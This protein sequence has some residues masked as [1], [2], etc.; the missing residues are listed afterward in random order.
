[1]TCYQ[2]TNLPSG[3]PTTG[4]TSYATEA[5][6]N[7]AC[8][9]GACCEGVACSVKPA[10]QCKCQSGSC[11]GPDTYTNITNETGPRCREETQAECAARG[12]VW[13]CGLPCRGVTY[14]P[15]TGYGLGSEIC[16]PQDGNPFISPVFMGVGT[17]CTTGT[18]LPCGCEPPKLQ[19]LTISTGSPQNA[20]GFYQTDGNVF[21]QIVDVLGNKTFTL[22]FFR[23]SAA[24]PFEHT[25]SESLL[26][27]RSSSNCNFA[28]QQSELD[29]MQ[30]GEV[31]WRS[32]ATCPASDSEGMCLSDVW[33]KVSVSGT[34]YIVK[35]GTRDL[36]FSSCSGA[37]YTSTFL[38]SSFV[39]SSGDTNGKL[40]SLQA[41]VALA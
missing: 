9:E 34:Q 11:C 26:C 36:F 12:G 19:T 30:T 16:L 5:E 27:L 23:S 25:N 28:G 17:V 38:G 3:F 31:I 13:R 4:R 8:K 37:S 32:L 22:S 1:M 18:C 14:D 33:A 10:C 21:S 41:T 2:S 40:F 39:S 6:C 24:V 20:S 7:Q 35:W 29:A 15:A